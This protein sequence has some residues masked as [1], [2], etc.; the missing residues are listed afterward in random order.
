[1]LIKNEVGAFVDNNTPSAAF[2]GIYVVTQTG[3]PTAPFILTRSTDFDN[4]TP[5]GEV[6]GG[7]TFV[8]YGSTEA[9]TG[10]V[11]TTDAPVTIGSTSI[12]FVQF[13]G[14]GSY[15]AGSGLS[16]TG[17][18]FNVLTDGVT[19]EIN[20]SNQVAV[21]ASANLTTPNIGAATGTSLS[22]TGNINAGNV[23]TTLVSAT[24]VSATGNV[25]SGNILTGGTVSATGNI[26]AGNIT[27]AGLGNI[28]T[29]T[30]ASGNVTAS[31]VSTNTTSGAFIITGGL[32]VGGNVYAGALYDNGTA[33]LT[34]NSTV[35]GGTY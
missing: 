28:T 21:K 12:T 11:C 14:A 4:G 3:S 34:V 1:V 27:T 22:V 23:S 29:L 8:E 6:P 18:Q 10:W 24:T 2:N 35:D 15:S 19:T 13:S 9:D 5:S 26:T 30:I 25:Q 17:T 20:G 33:V 31:T 32:G 7:F 16:L